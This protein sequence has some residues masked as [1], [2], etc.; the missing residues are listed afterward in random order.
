MKIDEAERKGD[1]FHQ[2]VCQMKPGDKSRGGR[3][4]GARAPPPS[5]SVSCLRRPGRQMAAAG[6]PVEACFLP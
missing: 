5:P 1:P 2:Q 4:R 3:S 6:V